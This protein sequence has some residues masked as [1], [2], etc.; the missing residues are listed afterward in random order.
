M[1][2]VFVLGSC[3]GVDNVQASDMSTGHGTSK[4]ATSQCQDVIDNEAILN[5]DI[6][7]A[8]F[9]DTYYNNTIKTMVGMKWVIEFCSSAQFVLFVDD[10]YYVSTKNLLKFARNPFEPQTVDPSK[11]GAYF[12]RNGNGVNTFD[13]RLYTG[14][15]FEDS[16]PMRHKTSKWYV[17]LDEYPFSKYP[18]YVTAGAFLLSRGALSDMYYTSLYTKHFRFDDIFVALLA[19]KV[20]VRPLHNHHFHFWRQTY[21]PKGYGSVIASHGF[22]DSQDMIQV[23]DEQRSLGNA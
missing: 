3:Q 9:V 10:D 19:K 22:H 23:W 13:G 7:Q 4:Q 17:S 1:K 5:G 15:V 20:G 8:D 2:R 16:S 14:Y 11:E 6:V 21:S 12:E 18:P